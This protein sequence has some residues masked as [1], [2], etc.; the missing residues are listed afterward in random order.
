MKAETLV[1]EYLLVEVLSEEL[2][3][4]SNSAVYR[5]QGVPKSKS[6]FC[7]HTYNLVLKY[8]YICKNPNVHV[9]D[10]VEWIVDNFPGS[11]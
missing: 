6:P 10:F 9:I 2:S 8:T 5:N 3:Q 1:A 4:V 11:L 7:M